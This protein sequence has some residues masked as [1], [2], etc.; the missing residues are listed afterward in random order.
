[1]EDGR[2]NMDRRDTRNGELASRSIGE[3]GWRGMKQGMMEVDIGDFECTTPPPFELRS[4]YAQLH[5]H[6]NIQFQEAI[7][8]YKHHPLHLKILLPN[9]YLMSPNIRSTL[10]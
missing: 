10:L 6:T 3:S 2:W 4:S 9:F 8:I 5:Q 7:I 1:M